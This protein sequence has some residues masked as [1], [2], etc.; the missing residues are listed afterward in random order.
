LKNRV[1]M[2]VSVSLCGGYPKVV[3][4]G[5]SFLVEN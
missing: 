2:G 3:L 5:E 1:R 4:G